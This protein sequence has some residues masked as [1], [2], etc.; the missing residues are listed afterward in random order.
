M[1]QH[2]LAA[3]IEDHYPVRREIDEI[4][5]RVSG[6]DDTVRL[7]ESLEHG[8][9]VKLDVNAEFVI[10]VAP[11][12]FAQKSRR[13][14]DGRRTLGCEWV[15]LKRRDGHVPPADVQA[16]PTLSIAQSR[17]EPG[18]DPP[19]PIPGARGHVVPH[20]PRS[21]IQYDPTSDK[22][23]P[24]L[25]SALFRLSAVGS[26]GR[27]PSVDEPHDLML[28][29]RSGHL[30]KG[31]VSGEWPWN[32]INPQKGGSA[33]IVLRQERE[34]SKLGVEHGGQRKARAELRYDGTQPRTIGGDAADDQ[35]PLY[36]RWN[37]VCLIGRGVIAGLRRRRCAMTLTE[38]G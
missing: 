7:A 21:I 15:A 6:V 30:T 19:H 34:G 24:E 22:V 3:D 4:G 28:R 33:V 17:S 26:C 10:D 8:R 23:L 37:L 27:A 14:A 12:K 38:T 13:D 2:R 36:V 9:V 31:R 35:L 29:Y 5:H 25:H 11:S 16:D 1:R 32:A 18:E 20:I